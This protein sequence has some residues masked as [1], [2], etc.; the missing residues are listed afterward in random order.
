MAAGCIHHAVMP[1]YFQKGGH[2]HQVCGDEI[3]L[4]LLTCWICP[5]EVQVTS[6]I[7]PIPLTN[8]DISIWSEAS[9]GQIHQVRGSKGISSPQT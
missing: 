8:Q 3:P 1:L 7:C 5:V 6:R 4:N 9:T 2:F